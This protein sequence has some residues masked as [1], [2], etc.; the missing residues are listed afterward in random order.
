M[1]TLKYSNIDFNFKKCTIENIDEI[2]EIQEIAFQNLT[3]T[4]LLRR[5]TREVLQTC[6]FDPHYTL[7]VFHKDKLIAFAVLYDGQNTIENIGRDIGIAEENLNFVVNFKLVIVLPDYRGNGLQQEL[8][9]KLEAIAKANNKR[10][11]CATISP[12]NTYSI[13]NFERSGFKFHSK[14]TKYGNLER[15]IYYK[16]LN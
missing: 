8:I 4:N 5:N 11:M 2:C 16:N 13:K 7:G 9:H 3:D 10:I 15:C 14:K 1:N 6:L 12:F